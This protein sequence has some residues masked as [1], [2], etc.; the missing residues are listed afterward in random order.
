MSKSIDT[1][2]AQ[3]WQKMRDKP[4][5]D[6]FVAAHLSTNIAAQI[7]TIREQRGWTKKTL[8]KKAGMS[9]SRITV[10]ED[11]SY[12]KF[13]LTTLKRLASAF[14]VA[15]IARFAPFSDL[16]DW[17]AELSPEKLETP[18]FEEDSLAHASQP[19][20][21]QPELALMAATIASIAEIT[22]TPEQN[23]PEAL[24]TRTEE[25]QRYPSTLHAFSN[26]GFQNYLVGQQA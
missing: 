6:A 2:R 26:S 3:L 16:A 7:Q 4:Y 9:P 14:D 12:E 18:A 5:R 22:P 1:I 8:A 17:V 19:S 23:L 25:N 11:P 15:L 10:M 21:N 20:A 13:T 24:L